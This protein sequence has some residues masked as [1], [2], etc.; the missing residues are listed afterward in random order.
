MIDKPEF[1]A[2]VAAYQR[3][4]QVGYN[5]AVMGILRL[6][7]HDHLDAA[8][9]VSDWAKADIYFDMVVSGVDPNFKLSE[10]LPVPPAMDGQ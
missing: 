6:L 8:K 3:G 10:F 4:Q 2:V 7:C 5:K 1:N 9:L